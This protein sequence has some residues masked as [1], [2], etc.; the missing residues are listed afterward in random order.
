MNSHDEGIGRRRSS[1]TGELTGN[2]HRL[3]ARVYYADTDFSGVVYHARYLEFM[4]RGRI[5]YLRL[6]GEQHAGEGRSDVDSQLAWIVRRLQV[7]FRQPARIDDLIIIETNPTNISGAR[8]EM[9]QTIRRGGKVLIEA[10]VECALVN[11]DGQPQRLPKN[12]KDSILL[13]RNERS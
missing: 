2:S 4:E 13:R 1:L 9:A 8:V 11:S 7:H 10:Q 6:V 3:E 5:E 12:W